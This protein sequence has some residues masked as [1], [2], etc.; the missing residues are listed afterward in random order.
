MAAGT[1]E[2]IARELAVALRL[3]EQRMAAD[4]YVDFLAALGFRVPDGYAAAAGAIGS[5]AVKSADLA[6]GITRLA[7]AIEAD[8]PATILAEGV[9]LLGAVRDLIVAIGALGPALEKVVDL[10]NVTPAERNQ[11]RAQAKAV[12]GRLLDHV[13]VTYLKDRSPELLEL[14]MLLG[15]VDDGTAPATAGLQATAP[16]GCWD[17]HLG[18]L[19]DLLVDPA[20]Y[21]A[22]HFDLGES[23]FDGTKLWP[24]IAEFLD[25]R[26]LPYLLMEAPD[27]TQVLEAF[28]L[29]FSVK[30]GVPTV[31]L[32]LAPVKDISQVIPF[33]ELWS[34]LITVKSKSVTGM[35]ARVPHPLGFELQLS[36]QAPEL[37]ASLGFVADRGGEH[38]V[39]LGETGASRLEFTRLVLTVGVLA[40]GNQN[41]AVEP[42]ASVELSGGHL[43]IDLSGGDSFIRAITGGGRLESTFDLRALWTPSTGLRLSG[44]AAVELG[45]PVHVQLGPIEIV[46]LYLRAGLAGDGS[47]P[48]ELS[49]GFRAA[50]GP[51]QATVDRIGLLVTARF[52]DKGGNL[53]PLD[54]EFGFKPPNGVGLVVD[55]GVVR[56][57]GY[58][59]I[60]ADRGEYAGALELDFAGIVVLKAIGLISTRMPDGS[61]G[62]SLLI[63]ITAEFGTGIQLGFGFTLL[64]VGGILG[65]N[66]AMRLQP[67]IDGVRS[68][69]VERILFPHDVVDNAPQIISDLRAIFPAKQGTFVIGPMVK[70]GWGTPT[71]VRVSVAVIIEIP[72]DA[73]VVGVL[74]IALPAEEVA[75]VLVQMAFVGAV[76]RDRERVWFF[77]AI[78]DSRILFMTLEGDLGVLAAFGDDA[79]FV[80]SLGGFHPSYTP[81]P[82]PF[83]TPRRIALDILNT[84]TQGLRVEGYFALTTNT[85]QFGARVDLRMGFSACGL[86]G[87]VAFD[88]LVQFSPLYF[89]V[90][91]SGS[92]SLDVFGFGMASVRLSFQ[93]SGPSPW[94]AKGTAELSLLFFD[95]EIDFDVTWG[96]RRDTA[97]PPVSAMQVLAAELGKAENWRALPP[98]GAVPLVSLRELDP[99]VDTLVLH[100][101]GMLRVTQRVVPLDVTVARIGSQRPA[102]ASRLSVTV[103]STD[104]TKQGDVLERFAPAQF[105]D[106][107][108]DEKLSKPAFQAMPGG[109]DVSVTGVQLTAGPLVTRVVRY[110]LVTV[111]GAFRTHKRYQNTYLGLFTRFLAGNAAGRCALSTEV[112]KQTVP[113]SDRV[114]V[115]GDGYAV[116][117]TV[118]NVAVATFASEAMATD[119]LTHQLGGDA[120]LHVIPG[121]EVAT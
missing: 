28:R 90:D 14:L 86:N 96:E 54:L 116:A 45:I 111:D 67:M 82:M 114:K 17:L 120:A 95:I 69:S 102:D 38:I 76:E 103:A 18:R 71:L 107:G 29:R 104:L 58:L 117:S 37:D 63:I 15:I 118:D 42:T 74:K 72:G 1:V 92:V 89:I 73:A 39:V 56:G 23:D 21:L 59:Y 93:L 78:Y 113:F 25:G 100:P 64:G 109:L 51:I 8:D 50:I 112:R 53:G 13:V 31:Q 121:Y 44:S 41:A 97:L 36:G 119:Y 12:P 105:Q 60:D 83:P 24:R 35:V 49:G 32:R 87:H 65:L 52:P 110:E 115:T 46:M 33:G 7:D 40:S 4:R 19:V 77:G 55:A 85:L 108:D 47:V 22:E 27:G 6:P 43:L 2:L 11:L 20:G 99:V 5:V 101:V 70:L 68:G 34:A 61:S 9:A 106:F 10:A 16:A 79:D 48:V 81:P 66:R 80:L 91:I 57:G 62:F 98:S 88:A 94:R 26:D 3:L 84:P 75:V 30:A